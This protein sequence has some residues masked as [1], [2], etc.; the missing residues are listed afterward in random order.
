MYASFVP[1]E[2]KCG[3][4]TKTISADFSSVDI[5]YKIEDGL[6]GLEIGVLGKTA[7]GTQAT[8]LFIK[9]N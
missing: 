5:Y 2:S 7:S 3:V 1:S 9:C 4:E 6:A 8:S